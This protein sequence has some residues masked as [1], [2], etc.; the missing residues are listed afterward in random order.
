MSEPV[1]P[2]SWS[3]SPVPPPQPGDVPFLAD[4]PPPNHRRLI[5][6]VVA[7]AA[8]VVIAVAVVAFT[9]G[10]SP[11]KYG[12]ALPLPAAVGGFG[13]QTNALRDRLK[14]YLTQ[15]PKSA[16]A[17]VA[18]FY[19]HTQLAVY[20]DSAESDALLLLAGRT[21]DFPSIAD[22]ALTSD[23]F[24]GIGLPEPFDAG[25]HGGALQCAHGSTDSGVVC[26]W[27]DST[28]VGMIFELGGQMTP[29]E[30]A[31]LTNSA[32]DTIDR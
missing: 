21:S 9:S 20:S 25:N 6:S 11:H 10:S 13:Q 8:A 22:H 32:R 5:V 30:L 2:Y 14:S 27:S 26:L 7:V 29:E 4:A 31:T 19:T 12:P 16:S 17:E 18:R 23:Y 24:N 28:S 15:N 1:D 3:P